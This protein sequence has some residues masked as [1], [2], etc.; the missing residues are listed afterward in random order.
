MIARLDAVVTEATSAFASFDYARALERTESFFWW[1]TDDYVELVKGRAYGSRGEAPAASA[2]A[3]LTVAL[4]TLQRLF[5]PFLPFATEECWRWWHSSSVHTA[6]WPIPTGVG[7]RPE[8]LDPVLEVL[9]RV[10]RAKTEAKVGQRAPVEHVA[11][12][13]PAGTLDLLEAGRG[14]LLDAGSISAIDTTTGDTLD[15]AVQLAPSE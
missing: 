13:A 2:K 9:A 5:A 8:L 7:E 11:V 14:D 3:A 12:T 10:R 15:V 6:E 4:D 1:F